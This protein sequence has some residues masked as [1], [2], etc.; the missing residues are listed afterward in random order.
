MQPLD[1]F[2]PAIYDYPSALTPLEFIGV[3]TIAFI[4]GVA[5]QYIMDNK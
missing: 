2:D 5:F 1:D 4:V 3:M